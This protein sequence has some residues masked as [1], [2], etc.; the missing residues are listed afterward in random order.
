MDE[1]TTRINYSQATPESTLGPDTNRNTA[2]KERQK[3]QAAPTSHG[4]AT[5]ETTPEPEDRRIQADK[6]RQQQ[7]ENAN[8][9]EAPST[10]SK[11]AA[12]R[13]VESLPKDI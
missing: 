2:D 13:K 12:A 3:A 9:K 11:S 1:A 7:E 6:A 5:P 4:L 8:T 10:Q